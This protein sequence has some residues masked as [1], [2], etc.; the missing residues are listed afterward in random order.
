MS[1]ADEI[2]MQVRDADQAA[3][4]EFWSA[5]RSLFSRAYKLGWWVCT[6]QQYADWMAAWDECYD[7]VANDI[8]VKRQY[9]EKRARWDRRK[10]G[11]R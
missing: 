5:M 3:L 8:E 7:R 6:P 9:A 1:V 4:H 10:G 11:R 2:E